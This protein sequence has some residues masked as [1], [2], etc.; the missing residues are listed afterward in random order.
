M[1]ISVICLRYNVMDFLIKCTMRF[2]VS[3]SLC[4]CHAVFVNYCAYPL[5]LL[6]SF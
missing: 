4:K 2:V 6:L 3:V 5:P 1:Y